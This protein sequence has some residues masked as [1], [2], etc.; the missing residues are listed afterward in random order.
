MLAPLLTAFVVSQI[1]PP[2]PPSVAPGLPFPTGVATT[3]NI[4]NWDGAQLPKVYQRSDQLPL[5]D[6]DLEKLA[7]EGFDAPMMIKMIEE[8]R[9]A[10]DASAEGMIRLKKAGVPK[11]VIQAVSLHGLKPNRH[12]EVL[13]TMDFSGDSR[14]ARQNF[15]YFFVDDGDLTGV[16]TADL[17]EL[18]TR[19]NSS[20]EMVDRSDL[21]ITKRVRRVRFVGSVPLKTYGKHQVLVV[22]SANPSLTHPSQLNALER[23]TAQSYTFDYPRA[24]LQSLC[25]LTAGYKRDAVLTYQWRYMG[26]RFECEWN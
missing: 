19:N 6:E 17:I 23:K 12:L 24:S 10:C 3:V 2:L 8:R 15:L 9:C 20:D 13:V 21:L 4:V 14:E 7:K 16:F 26:S 22:A 25:R 11:E 5:T 1:A 18:L